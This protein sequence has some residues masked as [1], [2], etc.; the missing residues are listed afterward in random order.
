MVDELNDTLK[1]K[2]Y[3]STY[4]PF[5]S[6]FV[7]SWI[8]INHKYL[9]IYFS[10]EKIEK[11]L[12]LLN[13]FDKDTMTTINDIALIDMHFLGVSTHFFWYPL[14]VALFYVYVYPYLS[15][16]FYKYTGERN[17]E[18]KIIKLE[19]EKKKAISE[20]EKE[21]IQLDNYNL[22][23]TIN[24]LKI[25]MSNLESQY[26]VEL[27]KEKEKISTATSLNI[28]LKKQLEAH[29]DLIH[30]NE[31]QVK[32]ISVLKIELDKCKKAV[33]NPIKKT[34]NVKTVPKLTSSQDTIITKYGLVNKELEV[35]KGIYDS[36]IGNTSY[37][38]LVNKI[39]KQ[40]QYNK[41]KVQDIL[42]NL[43]NKNIIVKD[44]INF[45]DIN[46]NFK[47]DMITL[48]DT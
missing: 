46:N 27:N 24:E 3:D 1:A 11:K 15:N 8:I 12:K 7:I 43:T 35:L 41:I 48:F 39:I 26:Q 5:M 20:K 30:E 18:K 13:D 40:T 28:E 14:A 36:N 16:M 2:L 17:N 33:L 4:T 42:I 38:N 25:K 34:K 47:K 10:T 32:E 22:T 6:S 29:N 44:N 9:A 31:L 37:D 45:Y 23:T 21:E 19:Y